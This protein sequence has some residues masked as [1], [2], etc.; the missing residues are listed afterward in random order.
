M[1]G[2]CI[3]FDRDEE[4]VEYIGM[5]ASGIATDA[6]QWQIR[7]ITYSEGKPISIQYAGGSSD[8]KFAWDDRADLRYA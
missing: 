4:D 6:E 2:T 7:K 3:L 1:N 8:Y 5:A